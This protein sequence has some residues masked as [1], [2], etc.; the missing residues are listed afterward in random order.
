MAENIT[1]ET[2]VRRLLLAWEFD[3]D[4]NKLM[5]F[6]D[7]PPGC[8]AGFTNANRQFLSSVA[9]QATEKHYITAKQYA[10]VKRILSAPDL[11]YQFSFGTQLP[12]LDSNFRWVNFEDE[13]RTPIM[14]VTDMGTKEPDLR[15]GSEQSVMKVG[16]RTLDFSAQQTKPWGILR[17]EG[18]ELVFEP[19]R[20]PTT[21][22]KTAKFRWDAD[23]KTWRYPGIHAEVVAK[24]LSIWAEIIIDES[25]DQALAQALELVELPEEIATHGTL[26]EFQKEAG[27]FLLS[28]PK[29]LLALAPGLGKTATSIIAAAQLMAD[30]VIS[31]IGIIAPKSLLKTWQN[32]IS[33]WADDWSCI[34][35]KDYVDQP[36]DANWLIINYDALS[37]NRL[38]E[39][40]AAVD[41]VIFDES[42]LISNHS[43]KK[44][45]GA[46]G[47]Q[48]WVFKTNRVQL[49]FE[50]AQG[51]DWVWLLSGGPTSKFVDDLWAQLH[52]ID[53][54]RFSSYWKF[55]E[56]Y[57]HVA[58]N[59]WAK[60]ITGNKP[61]AIAQIHEH[62]ADIIFA[63]SQDQVVDLPEWVFEEVE[64]PMSRKQEKAYDE[65]NRTWVTTL[66]TTGGDIQLNAPNTLA[67]VVRLSQLASNPILLGQG[68]S[69]LSPKW[70]AVIELM[71]VRPGPFIIWTRFVETAK[72]MEHHL[73]REGFRVGMLIGDTPAKLRQ[74]IVDA[75]QAGRLD[76]IVAHP[77]VGKFGLTLT[78]ARTSIYMENSYNGDDY[79]QS[80]H[81]VRRIGTTHAPIVITVKSIYADGRP[82]IDHLIADVL[83]AKADTTFKVTAAK[84]ISYLEGGETL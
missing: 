59:G 22:I 73:A 4:P 32:E 19:K 83:E 24:V 11:S 6:H 34:L 23:T 33:K 13:G 72:R 74:E 47:K 79:Y 58:Y 43:R 5:L 10:V 16:Q 53:P 69:A 51:V 36:L 44:E 26:F 46:D 67:Q 70:L 54:V 80:L 15:E 50:I 63:R 29:A 71:S 62:Y 37:R 52:I 78:A 82:T 12:N 84:L 39:E 81:R 3:Q 76:V 57:C 20:Y 14:T 38:P 35:H 60:E 42:I 8:V 49:A 45:T 56:E 77:A 2:I 61:G 75:F 65:M 40:M 9:R 64:V 21:Q 41:L 1:R 31:T 17:A 30:G 27:Q 25:V 66:E 28:H 68:I 55:A 7:L 48:R 18:S